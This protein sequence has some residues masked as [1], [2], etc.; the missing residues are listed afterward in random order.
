MK[1]FNTLLYMLGC[2]AMAFAQDSADTDILVKEKNAEKLGSDLVISMK[3]DIS[4]L[5]ISGGQSLVCTPLVESGDSVRALPPMIINGRSRHILYQRLERDASATGEVAVRRHN[6]TEQTIDYMVRTPYA[7]WMEKADVSMVMDDCGCGWEELSENK[8]NLFSMDFSEPV[9]IN[10]VLAYIVPEP[11]EVKAR[12]LD[13]S[14]FLD[15]PVNK[16]EIYPEYRKNPQE[17]RKIHE[18]IEVVRN[19]KYASITGI[20]VKGYASPE[21][22]YKNNTYLAE[23]RAKSL[24]DYVKKTYGLNDVNFSI[25]FEPEDWEGL[26]KAVENGSLQDKDEILAIIRADE[27]ADWDARE[28]KIKTLN[29]GVSYKIL[30]QDVYPGLRH[31]DYRVNYT[32]RSFTVDEAKEI[33]YTD[34]SKLSLSEMFAVAQQYDEGSEQF[35]EVFEIAVRM[36]PNDPV[37]NLNAAVNAVNTRQ[38]DKAKSYLAK[39]A[40]CPEKQLAEAS[41]LMLEDKLAEAET[42]LNKL[43]DYPSLA[44][45]VQENLNQINAKRK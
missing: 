23:H 6:D 1:L 20:T 16:T 35:G 17:L 42:I 31:S 45:K 18:T 9:V 2:S 28:W 40:D 38:L 13:G 25:D 3:V 39:A 37:S 8:S 29:G 11:E 21:G 27:P 33:I 10:P 15:F 36:Y 5:K 7:D 41:I 43:I 19:D 26:E 4:N 30:L 32:I 14:A 24:V 44:E 22:T 12:H 34:P